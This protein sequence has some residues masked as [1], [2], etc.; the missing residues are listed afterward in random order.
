MKISK[1]RA[2][3]LGLLLCNEDC[4]DCMMC[5]EKNKTLYCDELP[6]NISIDKAI[7]L[8]YQC[9]ELDDDRLRDEM[10][11]EEYYAYRHN[12]LEIE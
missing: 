9:P 4:Q 7:E 10:T 3:E 1:E 6:E 2:S 11:E 5:Y 12:G 8:G